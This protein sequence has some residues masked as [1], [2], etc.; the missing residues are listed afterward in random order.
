MLI[1]VAFG[2]S[3]YVILS[4]TLMPAFDHLEQRAAE[5]DMARAQQGL[6]TMEEALGHFATDWA[7][8]DDALEYMLGNNP[9]FAEVNLGPETLSNVDLNLTLLYDLAG[10]L[11]WGAYI[12]DETGEQT[13]FTDAIVSSEA[14]DALLRHDT[15]LSEIDG[16][17]STPDGLAF[18]SSRPIVHSDRSGPISGTLILGQLINPDRVRQLRRMTEVDLALLPVASSEPPELSRQEQSESNHVAVHSIED[19]LRISSQTLR[20]VLGKPIVTLTVR[21]P[22]RVSALGQDA[23]Q[24]VMISI[25]ILGTA[26]IVGI[27]WLLRHWVVSPIGRLQQTMTE[28]Q[29]GDDLSQR[30]SMRRTDEI[31]Q[32][33][34]A[35][36]VM[37]GKLE[38]SK[39]NNIEQSFKAG[40]AEVA[41]GVLHNI[42]NLL[43]PIVNAV[44]TA[45]DS[46]AAPA[47]RNAARAIEELGCD[48]TERER[49]VKLLRYLQA[50][51][52]EVIDERLQVLENLDSVSR[53]LDHVTRV[54]QDQEQIS[55][56]KPVLESVNLAEAID[57][58]REVLPA[59]DD[60]AVTIVVDSGL[61]NR[62]V[63]AHRVGLLQVLNNI[64]LN[65]HESILRAG[66]RKGEIKV[67]ADV[68]QDDDHRVRVTIC[69]TGAGIEPDALSQIFDRGFTSKTTGRGG[70]GL[71]W[72]ANAL[73]GMHGRIEAA[74]DG[75]NKGASFH[76]TL[77]AA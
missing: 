10:A 60:L 39:R 56:A 53:Q 68:G 6:S 52:D 20:D 50:T 3:T 24:S 72:T 40:I 13:E 36:N 45:R 42:R 48:S 2:S 22:R 65:A 18:I 59:T 33:A 63:R 73:A 29:D 37:V 7:H 26:I 35:F 49:R 25:A 23:V 77:Q 19:Q 62:N 14:I 11:R 51:H 75:A 57:A 74:S 17:I 71:H 47:G 30:I 46:V 66:H 34:N 15:P 38:E 21:S 9:R 64:L 58:A 55:H 61:A 4:N 44:A 70:L 12:D 31:G 27:W 43:M 16:F 67:G 28:I 54:L 41:A 1:V 69:D 76:I 5:E 32:L 8:W